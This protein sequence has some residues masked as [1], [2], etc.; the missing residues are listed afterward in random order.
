VI[1]ATAVASIA[2]FA[3][4]L[5]FSGVVRVAAGVLATTHRAVA[6]MRDGSLDDMARE[7]AIRRASMKLMADLASILV[8]GAFSLAAS[9]LPIWL[10]EATALADADAVFAFLARWDVILVASGV[11]VVGYLARIRLWPS[12]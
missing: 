9:L 10:G 5:W 11:M 3:A 1:L 2:F 7:Q 8:R 4:A 12:N 6:V